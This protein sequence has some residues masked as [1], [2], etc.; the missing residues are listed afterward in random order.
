MSDQMIS[1]SRVVPASPEQIFAVLT[2]PSRH[3]E[4]DGS[5]TLQGLVG[6]AE[7]LRLGSKFRMGVKNG[8]SYRMTNKVVEYEENRLIAW[9]NLSAHRWRY[10]L[11][12]VEGGTRVTET[13][14]YGTARFP[15]FTKFMGAE[16]AV[17]AIDA[18]LDRLVALFS[19]EGDS[20]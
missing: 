1:A 15:R 5:E 19:P 8:I 3:Q 16:K 6:E 10:E 7:T 20:D 12:P 9:C 2:D 13:F 11:A 4:I 17:V 18:T 14:D